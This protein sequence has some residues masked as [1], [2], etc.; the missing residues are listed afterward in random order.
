MARRYQIKIYNT[1]HTTLIA[2]LADGCVSKGQNAQELNGEDTLLFT[3]LKDHADATHVQ[4]GRIARLV[5]SG[6]AWERSYRIIAV[7]P[8]R[9]GDRYEINVKCEG[10]QYDLSYNVHPLSGSL[11][12]QTPTTHLTQILSAT[13][14][15]VGTVTPTAL[16]TMEYDYNSVMAD[17]QNLREAASKAAGVDYDLEFITTP[18]GAKTVSLKV[19]GV[20]SPTASIEFAK[21]LLGLTYED[22]IPEGNVVYG[23]GGEG[24]KGIPMTIGTATHRITAI[25]SNTITLDSRKVV[26]SDGTWNTNYS[27]E[28]PDGS[29]TV[30]TGSV[31]QVSGN[32]QLTLTSAAGLAVDDA[33]RIVGNTGL[34]VDIVWDKDSVTTYGPRI[35]HFQDENYAD[36][37]NRLGPARLSTLSGTYA[38]GLCEEWDL[39]GAPTVTENTDAQY[40]INGTKSQKVVVGNFSTTPSFV[41]VATTSDFAEME[42]SKHYKASYMTDGGEGDLTPLASASA[43]TTNQ[44]ILVTFSNVGVPAAAI[45]RRLYREDIDSATGFFK[46]ADIPITQ[47]VFFDTTPDRD[48]T[49]APTGINTAGGGEGISRTIPATIGEQYSAVIY[50]YITTGRVRCYL[51]SG[52]EICPRAN[53]PDAERATK[54]YTEKTKCIVI[55]SG[56]QAKASTITLNIVGH[57]GGDTFYVDSAMLVQ[58]PYHPPEDKF[59]ADNAA[60]E[61]FHKTYDHLQK[62]KNASAISPIALSFADLR[63]AGIGTDLISVGDKINVADTKLGLSFTGASA[64]RVRRKNTDIVEPSNGDVEINA[65]VPRITNDYYERR[66]SE[67]QTTR[68]LSRNITRTSEDFRAQ[69]ETS[70]NPMI[71]IKEMAD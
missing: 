2:T 71:I 14:W 44:A 27:V 12:D 45:M 48:L 28:K 13:S 63:E 24:S 54:N 68:S 3:I 49:V 9:D 36:V 16:V 1:S 50:L 34:D 69:I 15:T 5:R 22:K 30:I 25:A 29:L 32:D 8:R 31:K 26:S 43:V 46:I 20:T 57:D 42:G 55:I 10:L 21:N 41:S 37:F 58:S 64:P 52:G 17:L 18:G 35:I 38:S 33:I 56:F 67:R 51:S 23:R 53:L 60:T 40:V 62:S 59:V 19:V 7:I 4:K 65:T 70:R 39:V 6:D 61:L 66:K 47:T 11:I